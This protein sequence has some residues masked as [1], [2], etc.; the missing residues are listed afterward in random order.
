MIR[1]VAAWLLVAVLLTAWPSQGAWAQ[2]NPKD[3]GFVV[4]E[5]NGTYIQ[6]ASVSLLGAYDRALGELDAAGPDVTPRQ[7]KDASYRRRFLELRLL[8]DFHAFAYDRDQMKM[9]RDVVD[10]AYEGMG[11]YQ[12]ITDIEKELGISVSQDVV[13]QRK[14]EMNEAVGPMRDGTLRNN[15]RSFL[16]QPLRAPRTGGGP[17]L[18]D[19][20]GTKPSTGWDNVGNSADFQTGILRYLQ[21]ADLGIND[22]FNPD[23]AHY[24]HYIRKQIRDVVILSA[25]YPAT[26]DPPVMWSSRWTIWWTTT[27][28]CWKRLRRT[29]SR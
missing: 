12:D 6:A 20:I 13:N 18:W 16:A 23:Q 11:I 25:M 1:R 10:R 3:T 4:G 24:F 29:S 28:T 8:M 27:A 17:G 14:A 5:G 22:P 21:G 2:A 19:L 15:M 26:S 7:A 9:Y